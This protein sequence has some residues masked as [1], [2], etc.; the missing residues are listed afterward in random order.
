MTVE[1]NKQIVQR[2]ITAR[3][4]NDVGEATSVWTKEMQ[5]R[6]RAAFNNTT[7]AFPDL[8]IQID[9]IFGEGNQV[10]IAWRLTGTH[11]AEYLQIPATQRQVTWRG[12]DIYTIE[13]G[14]IKTIARQSDNLDLLKQLGVTLTWQGETIP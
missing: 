10:A 2:W 1:E 3:N 11:S 6:V 4:N 9:T 8:H 5:E 12:I 7:N 14:K 13:N